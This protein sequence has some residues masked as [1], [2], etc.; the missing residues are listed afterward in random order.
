MAMNKNLV[1][2]ASSLFPNRVVDYAFRQ[3]TQP[4][5]RKLRDRELK[6]LESAEKGSYKFQDLEVRTYKWE[7]SGDRV[8]LIHGWEGQ[9]GNFAS[10][11]PKLIEKN[12][13]VYA[14][15]A[16]GHGFSQSGDTS[17]LE[18]TEVVKQLIQHY[19]VKKLVSHSFGGV[20]TTYALS[21]IPGWEVDKYLLFTT[22]DRF[23]QRIDQVAEMMGITER[24]KEKLLDRIREVSGM[25]P[26]VLNVSDFVKA[27]NVKEALIFHDKNDRVLPIS[28][29]I[30]VH[31]H[32]P[33]SRLQTVEGT[34]HFRILSSEKILEEA[35]AFIE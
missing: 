25:Q 9:A 22:P 13:S 34:G 21:Q 23:L 4:Q 7:G 30:H 32:W 11:I 18:F 29:S 31:E 33:Q 12:F 35:V 20:A 5:V 28:Q 14:F 26:E 17:L 8:L 2:L 6:L 3:L 15:D 19:G 1:R 24:V 10:L 16:P 27:I